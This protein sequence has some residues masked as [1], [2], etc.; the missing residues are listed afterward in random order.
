MKGTVSSASVA[1]T[2]WNEPTKDK[3]KHEWTGSWWQCC[4]ETLPAHRLL[5]T[6]V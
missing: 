2:V 4:G 6:L 3:T 5:I 1:T